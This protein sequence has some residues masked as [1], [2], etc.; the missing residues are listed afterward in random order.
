MKIIIQY[1][2]SITDPTP[3]APA[4][5]LQGSNKG[6]QSN[7]DQ[8]QPQL[9]KAATTEDKRELESPKKTALAAPSKQQIISFIESEPV[10]DRLV[11]IL[12]CSFSLL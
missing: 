9:V 2:V 4:P 3:P 10:F 11:D 12:L 7:D 8:H 1:R 5:A 6:P